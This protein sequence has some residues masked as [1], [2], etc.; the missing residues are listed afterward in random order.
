MNFSSLKYSS[1]GHR[2]WRM[3]IWDRPG[4]KNGKV[5][6]RSHQGDP[7]VPRPNEVVYSLTALGEDDHGE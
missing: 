5:S 3:A 2:A 7:S 4:V 6:S 1:A